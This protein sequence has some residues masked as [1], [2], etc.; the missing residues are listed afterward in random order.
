MAYVPPLESMRFAIEQVLQA[1]LDWQQC[2]LL[3]SA[4]ADLAGE[5][6]LQAGRL[7]TDILAPLN[8][9]GDLQG[10]R[11]R[12]SNQ[13]SVTTPDGFPAAWQRFVEGGW[14]ALACDEADGGQGLP[15]LLN[16]AL[17]EMLPAANHG[18]TMYAGLLHGAYEALRHTA[19]AAL[20]DRYL[21]EVV[22]GETLVTMNL[23]EPAA[24]SDLALLRCK[25]EPVTAGNAANG[26]PVRITGSKIF[27]SGGEH[28]LT[29]TSCTS[30]SPACPMR[31][32][33]HAG[34]RSSS[35]PRPCPTGGATA[36]T[37]TASN[38]RWAST[39]A[40]PARC[41]LRPPR[42]GCWANPAAAS[43]PCS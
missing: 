15:Q 43:R 38:T 36:S 32:P 14:P 19:T 41:A 6:L 1:P 26:D 27:I 24:G 35:C 5:V 30:C 13:G 18:W 3:A 17:F 23:T 25:A 4:D 21:A 20:R 16:V 8:A 34:S 33:A 12:P 37:A 22:S 9:P 2:P 28:D 7:A 31:Q 29:E 10:C 42:A 39:A 40:A 11:W